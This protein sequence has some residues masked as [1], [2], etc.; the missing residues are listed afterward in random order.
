MRA[1]LA[2]IGTRGDVQPLL[3]VALALRAGGHEAR[4]CVPEDY[5][6]WIQGFGFPATPIAPVPW[7]RVSAKGARVDLSPERVQAAIAGQFDVLSASARDCDFLISAAVLPA[8]RTVTELLGIGYAFAAICPVML[9]SPYHPP[10]APPTADQE[11]ASDT[12]VN[13]AKWA[14]LAEGQNARLGPALNRLRET[15]GLDPVDDVFSHVMTSRP[16]LSA[17]PVLGP[18]PDPAGG[19]ALQTGAWVVQDDRPLP[20]DLEA[21]LRAGEPPVYVG[22]GSMPMEAGLAEVILTAA[23]QAGRRAIIA[24]GQAGLALA[25]RE[26]DCLV[27]GDVNNLRLFGQVAA[28]VHHGGAGTTAVAGMAGVPQVVV[29][30]R[31]DQPYWARRVRELGIGVAHLPGTPTAD[32]LVNA[33]DRALAPAVAARARSV[34]EAMTKDGA[35][36][37][38]AHLLAV[39]VP[40]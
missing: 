11:P 36:T 30:Q 6:D 24:S 20:G 12:A 31:F 4:L 39:P 8:A 26:P 2:T 34:S 13:S 18:W 22:F 17:D 9:P 15:A 1:L 38:A 32:S 21:F 40:Q 25:S 28:V 5:C 33:L 10:I 19:T 7:R 3:A 23:R 37:A 35:Q 16:W 27:V 29:P 14:R